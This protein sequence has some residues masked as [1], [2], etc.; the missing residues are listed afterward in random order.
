MTVGLNV[1]ID[2]REQMMIVGLN[3]HID[4]RERVDCRIQRPQRR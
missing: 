1:H 3:V 2:V 4:V